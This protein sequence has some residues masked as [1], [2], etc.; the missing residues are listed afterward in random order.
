[1]TTHTETFVS[2][3]HHDGICRRDVPFSHISRNTRPPLLDDPIQCLAAA[4]I[5]KDSR[6]TTAGIVLVDGKRYFV[7][8][9][10]YPT[11]F[12]KL[13][14]FLRGRGKSRAMNNVIVAQHLS[15]N[16]ILAPMVIS[17][18]FY[19]PRFWPQYDILVTEAFSEPVT[20]AEQ[21]PEI[22]DEKHIIRLVKAFAKLLSKIHNSNVLHGDMKLEN[23]HGE[24]IPGGKETIYGVFDFDGSKILKRKPTIS[25][26]TKEAA[27]ILSSLEF[28]LLRNGSGTVNRARTIAI[29]LD[30]YRKYAKCDLSVRQLEARIAYLVERNVRKYGIH[31]VET[32]IRNSDNA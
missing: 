32:P 5:V 1:M 28:L 9:Y 13:K 25:E 10:N 20:V 18:G 2:E 11:F 7:K 17:A 31:T 24:K 29:F 23:I 19:A 27:R 6:S 14:R 4:K 21:L 30:S 26:R 3:E 22:A 12:H 16:G 8:R 15:R